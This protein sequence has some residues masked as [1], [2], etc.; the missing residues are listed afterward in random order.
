MFLRELISVI[1]QR[2]QKR[3]EDLTIAVPPSS[4][5]T[6]RAELQCSLQH[7]K[8][9]SNFW[10]SLLQWLRH[11][12]LAFTFR[13]IDEPVASALGYGIDIKR[14]VTLIA[15]DFGAGS[16]E[17]AAVR[18]EGEKPLRRVGLKFWRNRVCLLAVTMLMSGLLKSLSP[19][20]LDPP[21]RGKSPMLRVTFSIDADRWDRPR[22]AQKN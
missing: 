1:E 22:P 8:R 14:D 4:Y 18:V 19:N 7:I 9:P 2:F 12:S 3:I 15:F 17:V 16:L 21:G 13:T 11:R 6:Y 20:L 5:E 10:Q